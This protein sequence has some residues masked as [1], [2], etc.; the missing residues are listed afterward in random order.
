MS[1]LR[2]SSY[3]V[4]WLFVFFDLPTNTKKQ[5]KNATKFRKTLEKDGFTMKQFSVYVR[6]APS[7]ENAEVHVK[8]VRLNVPE[9]G[10]VCILL[11][12]DKQYGNMINIWGLIEKE[13]EGI[14]QQLELF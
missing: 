12:T 2:L 7:K 11:V 6:H 10:H 1:E 4:M 9:E 13:S 3:R 5:R 8:R 14:P